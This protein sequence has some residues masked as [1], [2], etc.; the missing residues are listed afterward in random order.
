MTD[1]VF[2]ENK[3]TNKIEF[4]GDFE[5]YIEMSVMG[6]ISKTKQWYSLL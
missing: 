1:K 6:S 2:K 5:S 4:I 3:D